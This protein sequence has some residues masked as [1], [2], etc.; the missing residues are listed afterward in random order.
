MLQ[1][2]LVLVFV[3]AGIAGCMGCSSSSHYVYATLP[4]ASELAVYREDPYSGTLTELSG[5][6]YTVGDGAQ[7]VVIHP[8]GKFLF[9]ANPG[10]GEND[11]SLF[12]IA[13]NGYLTEIPPRTPVGTNGNASQPSL[14]V[15]DTAGS[16]LYVMNSGSSNISVFSIDSSNG[17]LT[18]VGS[19][20][21]LGGLTPLNMRLTP[22]GSFLYVSVAGGQVGTANGSILGFSVNAGVLQSLSPPLTSA[23]GFNPNGLEI[24]PSGSYLYVA[25]TQVNSISIFAISAPNTPPGSLSQVQGSPLST[26]PYNGPSSLLID[27]KGKYLYVANQGSNNVAV[28]SLNSSGLPVALTTST[29]AFAFTTESNPSFLA[30]DPNG[31]YMFVGN[32]GTGA[33]IQAFGVNSGNLNPL[34]TYGVG[35]TPSSIAITQ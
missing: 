3:L 11:I 26:G 8:S 21:P 4:A 10:Q 20:V 27:S 6:P 23:E 16:Y 13:T 24:D 17:A 34:F 19:P 7:S 30:E 2:A 9:V 32:Q 1:K 31:N 22:S 35:N 5:T 12:D 33:G 14:L 15:M 18:P 25:N 28:Y 29:S